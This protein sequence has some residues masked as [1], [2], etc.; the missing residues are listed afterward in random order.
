MQIVTDFHDLDLSKQ[1]T[2]ADYLQWQFA[3]RVELLKG[4]IYKMS[5]APNRRHQTV[6]QRINKT[7]LNTISCPVYVAPF[8]V[9]LPIASAKKNSTVVQ[10]DL[11]VICDATKLDDYGC[12]G[13]PDLIVE[14]LSPSNSKHDIST[15]FNLYQEA[16]VQEYWIV[17]IEQRM[18]LV[19]ALE[20]GKY[21]GLKPFS[22][23][24]MVRSLLFPHLQV[25]VGVVFNDL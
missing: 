17:D 23:D 24:D 11:C 5:P 25:F 6:S 10:P 4:F 15:K 21:I 20:N 9:R 1:Y 22:E 13:A 19:Y 14:I 16:G 7:F 18:I 12:N 8:D 2:F 3:E